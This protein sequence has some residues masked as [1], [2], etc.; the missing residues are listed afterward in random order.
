MAREDTRSR[1]LRAS[2]EVHQANVE[3]DA[4]PLL[5]RMLSALRSRTTMVAVLFSLGVVGFVF[6]GMGSLMLLLIIL[7]GWWACTFEEDLPLKIPVQAKMPDPKNNNKPGAGIFYFGN[8][9]I[10]GKQLWLTNDDVRQHM[11]VIGTTGAGKA[12]PLDGKVHTPTGWRRMGEL[13]VGDRVTTPD[14]RSAAI[15]GYYPQGEVEI[16]RITFADGRT[17]EACPEHLWEVHHKHWNGKYRPGE[18]RSGLAKPRVL[19]TK[20]I[21]ELLASNKGTF[22]VRLSEPVE[23]PAQELALDPYLL[24]AMLG[25]GSISGRSFTFST[26]DD[27]LKDKMRSLFDEIGMDLVQYDSNVEGDLNVTVR[28]H[29]GP[30]PAAFRAALRDLGLEGT[31]SHEKF[32]PDAYKNGSIAQ[33]WGVIQGLMDTD[34]TLDSRHGALSF[35]TSSEQLAKD[36]QEIIWSLGGIATIKE[37][38]KSFTG[39]DGEKR[40]GRIAYHLQIRHPRRE[41]FFSL[42]RKLEILSRRPYQYAD[43]LKLKIVSVERAVRRA[44]AACILIDHPEHLFVAE[45]YVA[46][47]NT[48]TL[49]GFVA[50]ALTWSSGFLFCDGKGD[51]ALMAKVYALARLFNREDDLLVLNFMTGNRD[52]GRSGGNIMSN[53]LNPFSSGSSDGLTQMVVS[54]M[55]DAGGDGAMWKGRATAMFT[56]VMR[57]LTWLRDEDVVD[58]N[59]GT[60]RDYLNLRAIIDLADPKIYP[61]MPPAIR[62]SVRSY[63]TSLPGFQEDKG[64]KQA[65]TT[66]DQH[67][68]LEMQFTKILGSLADVYGHIFFTESGEVDMFD[69][70]LNRRLLVIMLPALEKAGDEIANL[71]KIVVAN[72]KGMMGAT[73]GNNIQGNWEQIVDNRVTNSPSPFLVCL[74]EVGYYTVDGMALMCAQARSLGFGLILASQDIPAMKRLN[75]KEAASIIANTNT[76]IFMRL[77]EMEQSGDLA[78]K[79][80]G[81][82]LTNRSKGYSGNVSE[83]GVNWRDSMEA[84]FEEVDRINLRDLRRQKAGEMT[85]THQDHVI[86]AV[87]FY[88]DPPGSL[89][90]KL[91]QLGTNHFIKVPK[92]S[93]SEIEQADRIPEVFEH[94]VDVEFGKRMAAEQRAVTARM[95][96]A[97]QNDEFGLAFAGFEAYRKSKNGGGLTEAACASIAN[98]MRAAGQ[99][100]D[101]LAA[102][103][104]SRAGQKAPSLAD[105]EEVGSGLPPSSRF[106]DEPPPPQGTNI[107][108]DLLDDEDDYPAPDMEDVDA[109]ALDDAAV[110]GIG[111]ARPAQVVPVQ[112]GVRIGGSRL[113]DSATDVVQNDAVLRMYADLDF[114]PSRTTAE[115]VD[116]RIQ[117]DLGALADI[118]FQDLSSAE[119]IDKAASESEKVRDKP[120]AN[121]EEALISGFLQ[122]LLDLDDEEK[123]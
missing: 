80:A 107:G 72:L 68:Y 4:R 104:N 115:D 19:Q 81:R 116:H 109:P 7:M 56:G 117:E 37:R 48:E 40:I 85:V 99:L 58:L 50:N 13:K 20:D 63:L 8:D 30:Q 102:Q 38:Q 2:S 112:H 49:L 82:G 29:P 47:H 70:V 76:K 46:T 113:E 10:T 69:V 27:F 66:L 84:G 53:T 67:G 51:V 36:M 23:K 119:S 120:P 26:R 94:L 86:E 122:S 45:N 25:D 111:S 61:E 39:R 34:G 100:G 78:L 106:M 71:G 121:S 88:A 89:N 123:S 44:E 32:I 103:I 24:G 62:K 43:S 5:T 73:L 64:H 65:Q 101:S 28:Q 3:R 114:E 1:G 97:P 52:L 6:P 14:G 79:S 108:F 31:L 77:E 92:P 42:P 90:K 11:L 33:R 21:E 55:D 54:L 22:S 83:V 98:V 110:R 15:L 93:L 57:A 35:T 105:L 12:L 9:R 95:Q 41:M 96:S 60:I 91:L 74:D 18:S 17:V 59:V 75:E 118:H 16:C 87:S